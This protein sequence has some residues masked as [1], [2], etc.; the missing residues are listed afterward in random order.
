MLLIMGANEGLFRVNAKEG[1]TCNILET[2]QLNLHA[3]STLYSFRH[4][5]MKDAQFATTAV[6]L[7]CH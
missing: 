4:T 3:T 1:L 7:V 6:F 5:D 2:C